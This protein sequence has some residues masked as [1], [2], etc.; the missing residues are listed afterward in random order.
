MMLTA[1]NAVPHQS[2][3]A[4]ELNSLVATSGDGTI[5]VTDLR[6]NK[7]VAQSEDDADDEL[8]SVVV[9]KVIS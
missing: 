2:H 9:L 6:R 7:V 5:T 8:L 1:D 4:Q 3:D